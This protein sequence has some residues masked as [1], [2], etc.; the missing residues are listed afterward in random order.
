MKTYGDAIA[1]LN[2]FSNYETKGFQGF[3]ETLDLARVVD[4]LEDLGR[5]DR[6]YRSIHVAGTK[7]KGSVC[8]YAASI[9]RE[10]GYRVGLYTSPHLQDIL[11]RIKIDGVNVRK[12]AFTE[13]V[14]IVKQAVGKRCA[15]F[16]YFE[17]L[18]ITAILV[19]SAVNVDIA[20][21]ETGL[22]GRLDATNIVE[23]EIS[24][25]TAVSFDHTDVLGDTIEKIAVEKAGIIK[26]GTTCVLSAQD[27]K[28]EKIIE[29]QCLCRGCGLLKVGSDI[30]YQ[31]TDK[32]PWGTVF[33]VRTTFRDYPGCR[34]KMPGFF[35]VANAAQAV[36]MCE[37]ML[38]DKLKNDAVK[39]GLEKAFIPGRLELIASD[40]MVVIDGAQN[41]Q[42]VEQLKYSIEEIFKYDKLI[43]LMGLSTGKDVKGVC[44]ALE[45]FADH[46]I[47]TKAD[48]E[49][50]LDPYVI[51]G[52]FRRARVDVAGNV[53]EAL[54]LAF[55]K[56]GKKDLILCAGSFYVTGEVRGLLLGRPVN[57]KR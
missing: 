12:D 54:G 20:V 33:N 28:A 10:A 32:G 41:R 50:A 30:T 44:K 9:L 47:L 26:R 45:A 4:L 57:S 46:V 21:F 49:R 17:I 29:T 5:P 27:M 43:L 16:T 51:R 35:Q 42:S 36:C 3:R 19:F 6:K 38:K 55:S 2:S 22:G 53:K 13:A 15:E 14:S 11:E 56:A 34:T 39:Q 37:Q 18:T 25:I 7:G 48:F 8:T 52:F 24:A 40:P 23:A 1:Y 31:I